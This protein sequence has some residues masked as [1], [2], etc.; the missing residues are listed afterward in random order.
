MKDGPVTS[1]SK[2]GANLTQQTAI[3]DILYGFVAAKGRENML[4]GSD[5]EQASSSPCQV[6]A[7]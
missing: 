3:F 7:P 6:K 5:I 2:S 4:L 1:H